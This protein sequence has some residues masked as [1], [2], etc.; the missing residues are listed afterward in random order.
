MKKTILIVDDEPN[1]RLLFKDE[2]S[3]EGYSVIE[4]ENGSVALKLLEEQ[5]IHLIVL[6]IQMPVMDGLDFLTHLRKSDRKIPVVLCTAYG[7]H[8]Q[9][10]VSWA[11]DRYIVKSGDLLELKKSVK[12]LLPI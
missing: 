6:D 2:F 11:A 7:Q 12:E 5:D 4:A 3:R 8:K 10:L 1:I 9:D